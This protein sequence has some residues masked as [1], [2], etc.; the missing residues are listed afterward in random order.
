MFDLPATEQLYGDILGSGAVV[1]SYIVDEL[2]FEGGFAA[3]YRAHHPDTGA[4]VALK[5]LRCDMRSSARMLERFRQ[6]AALIRRIR[7]PGIV[8]IF[9]LD[10]LAPGRPYI[11]ME[12]L[13][14][15]DLGDELQRR[16]P[17][18]A[19]ETS[20]IARDIGAALS[21][22]HGA[23]IIHRDVKAGNVIAVPA[24]DW[25]TCK[26]ID[27][28]IARLIARDAQDSALTTRTLIGTPRNMAPEQILGHEAD[29]RTDV[30]AL[31]LLAYQMVCGR[32]P[33]DGDSAIELEQLHLHAAPPSASESACV[34]PAFD[35]VIARALR[36]RPEQRYARVA[37][38][39]E[40]LA[41]VVVA[42]SSPAGAPPAPK[43]ASTT[44]SGAG[45]A[46]AIALKPAA[47][48]RDQADEWDEDTLDL[49]DD[50]LEAARALCV[51]TGLRIAAET[52]TQIFAAAPLPDDSHA[53]GATESAALAERVRVIGAV[54]GW[55][56]D[57]LAARA[58]RAIA[59]HIAIHSAELVTREGDSLSEV[60]GEGRP[61][62]LGGPLLQLDA[63]PHTAAAPGVVGTAAAVAGSERHF[64]VHPDDNEATVYRLALRS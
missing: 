36:K 56:R 53:A 15:R 33:F 62:L 48:A 43:P 26:L 55:Y 49:V 9:E 30:Y 57:Q 14:G 10:E 28:G 64:I 54:L 61:G 52:A 19:A 6:E 58:S 29:E 38:F 51:A 24:G 40:A 45:I 35:A 20:A 1:G 27:F 63:W 41:R 17:F 25:F 8:R 7:H 34:S 23:G 31:G 4:V 22:A 5:L 46:V 16:G 3:I 37:D 2:A 11:V 47:G 13:E 12:W 59:I 18:T 60:G 42:G 39:V 32:L 44:R 21:A 50:T